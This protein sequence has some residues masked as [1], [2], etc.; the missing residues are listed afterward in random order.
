VREYIDGFSKLYEPRAYLDRI[1][2][3]FLELGVETPHN[4]ERQTESVPRDRKRHSLRTILR[5]ARALLIVCWRQGVVRDT[6]SVFWRYAINIARQRPH[7][8]DPYL[9][10]CAHNEHFL[11]YRDRIR[12]AHAT[13]AQATLESVAA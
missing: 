12:R 5:F 7:L 6:R 9:V 11:V 3:F 10:M 13:E 1:Y 4:D 2:R 8:L